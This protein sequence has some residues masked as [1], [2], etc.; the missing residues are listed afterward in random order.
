M[1]LRKI[2]TLLF[3]IVLISHLC[4]QTE[5]QQSFSISFHPTTLFQIKESF[6]Q[7]DNSVKEKHED[8]FGTFGYKAVGY[9]I[10]FHGAWVATYNQW[11]SKRIRLNINSGCEFSSKQWDVYDVPDGPRKDKIYDYRITLMPGIDFMYKNRERFKMYASGQVGIEWV[12]RGLKYFDRSQRDKFYYA[13]QL[14]PLC[15]EIKVVKSFSIDW[16]IG[17]GTLG[18]FKVGVDYSF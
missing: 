9:D 14:W 16:G 11:M 8:V 2:F 15:F 18:L 6:N 1:F 3:I 7:N 13:G 10:Q 17:F 4:A 12:H 5:K